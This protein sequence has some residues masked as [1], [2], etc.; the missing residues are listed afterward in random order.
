MESGCSAA[1]VDFPGA[2]RV[3]KPW[4]NSHTRPL[5][6]WQWNASE[7]GAQS[8]RSGNVSIAAGMLILVQIRF[9]N[10]RGQ[11]A[12]A[13]IFATSRQVIVAIN[14]SEPRVSMSRNYGGSVP[15][16]SDLMAPHL[17]VAASPKLSSRIDN[18]NLRSSSA[19]QSVCGCC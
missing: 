13:N 7:F 8:T 5:W 6:S 1:A 11:N 19:S 14:R 12:H 17:W 15:W 18:F 3:E 9:K 4:D 16:L 10:S 2:C